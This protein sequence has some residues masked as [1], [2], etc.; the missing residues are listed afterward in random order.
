MMPVSLVSPLMMIGS[1]SS[2]IQKSLL[3]VFVMCLFH[4]LSHLARR[5][6]EGPLKLSEVWDWGL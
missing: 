3:D 1:I 5:L 6:P 2:V 4:A